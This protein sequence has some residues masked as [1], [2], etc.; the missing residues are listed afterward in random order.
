MSRPGYPQHTMANDEGSGTWTYPGGGVNPYYYSAPYESWGADKIGANTPGWPSV[1]GENAYLAWHQETKISALSHYSTH[2]SL[3]G[4][5]TFPFQ[6][7]CGFFNPIAYFNQA[8][9][10]CK[11]LLNDKLNASL[12]K[13]ILSQKVNVMLAAAEYKKTCGTIASTVR[14]IASAV[15]SVKGGNIKGAINTLLGG[16]RGDGK[17]KGKGPKRPTPPNSGSFAQDWLA[18][19]YGWRPL[20]SDIHGAAEKLSEIFHE[21]PPAFRVS[22]RGQQTVVRQLAFDA[23]AENHPPSSG[24]FKWSI[25]GKAC[26]EYGVSDELSHQAASTGITNPASVIWELVPYSFVVDWFIPVGTFLASLNYDNGLVFKRGWI[27]Y[28]SPGTWTLRAKS[29]TYTRSDGL[30]STWSGGSY[31]CGGDGFERLILGGFPPVPSPHFKDPR[32]LEHALNALA[33]L[34]VAF[35]GPSG[36]G[37]SYR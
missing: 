8:S 32:S 5:G 15:R 4:E 34:R 21:K 33:L 1:R 16:G 31:V 6:Y 29:G 14:R 25:S 3:V 22:A 17:G 13:K 27:T 18:I 11:P 19:Q 7:A 35:G 30:T 26:V 2:G 23:I 37:P 9:D 24:V 10:L 28:K 20:L 12:I 36:D